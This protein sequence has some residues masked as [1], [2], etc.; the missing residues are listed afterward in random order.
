[1]VV[2]LTD[3]CEGI[4]HF[5]IT[6]GAL[7]RYFQNRK[8]L[9]KHKVLRVILAR[10]LRKMLMILKF[11]FIQLKL[12]GIPV[13]LDLFMKT[14]FEPLNRPFTDPLSGIEID[15]TKIKQPRLLVNWYG[16]DILRAKPYGYQK[17]RKKGRIKRKIRRK[18]VKLVRL[19][20]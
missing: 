5:N 6:V 16:P 4:T 14:L 10:I 1:M 15:E 2:S 3:S 12:R 11:K 13:H 20:D 17:T 8:S 7:M 18:L 9:R 19:V